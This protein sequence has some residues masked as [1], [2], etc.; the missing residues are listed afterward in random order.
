[1]IT[2]PAL[3]VI[4]MQKDFC[5]PAFALDGDPTTVRSAVDATSAFLDR[6]RAGGR[7]PLLVRNVHGP[8]VDSDAWHAIYDKNDR[9]KPCI[10]G[11]EGAEFVPELGATDDD[12]VVTKNRYDAFYGTNLEAYLSAN[13]VS[14]LLVAGVQT[15]VCVDT[16]VRSAFVRDYRV[17]VL[18]DCVGSPDTERRDQTFANMEQYFADVRASEDVELPP[19]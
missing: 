1:M 4:D 2:D 17:T 18:E 7:T 13:D 10:R 14:H 5:D 3:V 6:Y 12:V 16:T 9:T 11:D 19:V 8:D 15:N